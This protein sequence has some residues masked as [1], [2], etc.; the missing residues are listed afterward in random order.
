M[1]AQQA[2]AKFHIES[3]ELSINAEDCERAENGLS[4]AIYRASLEIGKILRA[5]PLILMIRRHYLNCFASQI[6]KP[7]L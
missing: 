7:S 4:E 5:V 6:S 3:G 1:S 2:E